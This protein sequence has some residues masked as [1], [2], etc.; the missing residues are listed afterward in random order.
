MSGILERARMDV[1]RARRRRGS[2][3]WLGDGK[4]HQRGDM[5]GRVVAERESLY[6]AQWRYG[7]LYVGRGRH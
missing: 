2:A 5:S 1:S 4:T 3:A 6:L 7:C